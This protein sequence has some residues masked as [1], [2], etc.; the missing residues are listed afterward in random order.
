ME[1][2]LNAEQSDAL[3]AIKTF[4]R[5]ESTD[6]FVLRGCAGTGKTT[7]IAQ[8]VKTLDAMNLSC[9]L[10][11]PTGRAAR[12]LGNKIRRISGQ[13][14]HG[15]STIHSAIYT[16]AHVEVNENAETANDPGVRMIFP[17]RENEASVSLFVI[18]ESSMVGDKENHGDFVQFGSGRLLSDIVTFARA[19]RPGRTRDPLT[20]LLFVGDPA[21][22]PPVGENASPALSD[23]YL[24]QTFKLQVGSYDLTTVMRQAE[25]S[26]IL[27]R[28]TQLRTS[29]QA[30]SFNTF[31]LQPD[32]QTITQVD[33][34]SA[35]GLMVD[36]LRRKESTVTVVHANATALHYNRSIRE[37]LWG[38]AQRP[39]QVGDTLLIN[40]NSNLYGLTN[41]DLVKVSEVAAEPERVAVGLKGGH[42]VELI[43]RDIQ[44]V[45]REGDGRVIRTHCRVL[46]NLLDSPHRELAALEQRALLVDFL[47]RNYPLTPKSADF[48]PAIQSDLNFNALHIKYGYALTCHK[49]QGG[50]WN[51]VIVDF[52]SSA[53]GRNAAFFRWAYTAITRAVNKL[54]VVNPPDFTEV[55]DMAWASPPVASTPSN[56]VDGLESD[57]D[58][59]RLAFSAATAALL[60]THRQLRDAWL[61]LGIT[62]EHLHHL[63]YCERY[64]LV[65]EGKRA[66]VQYYYDKTHRMGRAAAV[67]G[68]L[69][70][71][72]LADAALAA[73][74]G[75]TSSQGGGQ[76][77]PFIDEFLAR[78][79]SALVASPIQRTG[80]KSM[81]Y[82]LRVN[83]ADATRKGAI[84][85]TY[86][87]ASCWT[88]AQEVGGPGASFGL[89]DDVQ[90][91]MNT[92]GSGREF[93]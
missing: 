74:H 20:K 32:Q 22:L 66:T 75:L 28:A 34:A 13:D 58:W 87:G 31:S 23:D 11:A 73:L 30:H 65:R 91:L 4:L 64:T 90:H 41:G 7:L 61:A 53:G 37:R 5:D 71:T 16:L 19:A 1:L 60:P 8:L 9:A 68:G 36:G 43:F 38:D 12:I 6:A 49:A 35:L 63:Q 69:F 18:D 81:P 52:A 39:L 45:Y 82:R 84:D 55:S 78:L 26:A 79:D 88:A 93:E 59:Q 2:Q 77:E 56:Q 24:Q 25:G 83:F 67:P 44:V 46:E 42:H 21:Q 3:A 14:G 89:Y 70:D 15:G 57:P 85:F 76:S 54:I 62:I 92:R 80:Y 51:T 17:L 29:I 47:K 40:R 48:R 72:T 86:D 10:L 33:V 27:D 50:E